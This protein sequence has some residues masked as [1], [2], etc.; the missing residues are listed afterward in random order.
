M[1]VFDKIVNSELTHKPFP[2]I[3]VQS[4]LEDSLCRSL[5]VSRPPLSK[6]APSNVRP[7]QKVHYASA[8]SL[9]DST[10]DREWRDLIQD[11]IA[12]DSVRKLLT[13]FGPAI[14]EFYPQLEKRYG[15]ISKWSIGQ[16][17]VDAADDCVILADAQVSY[18][19]PV[20]QEALQDRGPHL[21]ITNKLIICQ[22]LLKLEDDDSSGGDLQLYSIKNNSSRLEFQGDQEVV[23]R[24]ALKLEKTIPYQSNTAV[25][26]LNSPVSIQTMSAR[27][28]QLPLMYLNIILEHREPL[29]AL[30]Q[31]KP[32][33]NS[34]KNK[35][36]KIIPF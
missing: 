6:F 30:N 27:R 20:S 22:L 35:L 17:F 4:A 11:H 5:L 32:T 33:V 25:A 36:S 29:F 23:N 12:P 18:H 24:D 14:Q 10:L 28:S 34:W 7:G 1:S 3:V 31:P 2:H 26:F 8:K 9:Q 19:A 21:K 15:A 13:A 16:R